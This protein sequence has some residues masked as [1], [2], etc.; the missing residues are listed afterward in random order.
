MRIALYLATTLAIMAAGLL[1]GAVAQQA[2]Q[3]IWVALGCLVVA[4]ILLVVERISF[5]HHG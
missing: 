4:A 3:L 5:H 2:M 1:V